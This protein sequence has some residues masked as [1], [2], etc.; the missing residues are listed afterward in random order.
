MCVTV[1]GSTD[2]RVHT[3]NDLH[4]Q[5]DDETHREEEHDAGVEQPRNDVA[6]SVHRQGRHQA[7]HQMLAVKA[8]QEAGHALPR[9]S[10]P[11]LVVCGVIIPVIHFSPLTSVACK[12][13][14]LLTDGQVT[15]P[16]PSRSM[17]IKSCADCF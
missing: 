12:T 5:E 1:L 7:Q 15:S 6:C 3:I 4:D 13:K 11:L 14:P 2:A 10:A 8:L 17:S 9:Q 16:T